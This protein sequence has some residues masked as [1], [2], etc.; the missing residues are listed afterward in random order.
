MDIF[1]TDPGTVVL[2]EVSDGTPM[3]LYVDNWGG[4]NSFR[5]IITGF[6]VQLRGGAQFMHTLNEFIYVYTFGERMGQVSLSGLSFYQ[7]CQDFDEA[8]Q[9]VPDHG[10][11]EVIG[12]YGFNRVNERVL[13]VTIVL[14]TTTSFDCFLTDM[15]ADLVDTERVL[16]NWTLNLAAIPG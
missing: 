11:E 4:Y 13:P 7:D 2:A 6:R 16:G 8:L 15:S 5:S 1:S 14:G 12:Y 9:G 3:N 10:L